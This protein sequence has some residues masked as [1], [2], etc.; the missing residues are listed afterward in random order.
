M[1]TEGGGNVLSRVVNWLGG[2]QGALGGALEYLKTT[3][4]PD[5]TSYLRLQYAVQRATQRGELFSSIVG[6]SV[7]GIKTIMSTQLG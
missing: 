1:Q 2:A 4:K 3:E 5:I 6:S 7:S